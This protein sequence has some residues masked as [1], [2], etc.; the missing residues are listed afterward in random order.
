MG[1]H[2]GVAQDT[3]DRAWPKFTVPLLPDAT[4]NST[5]G[6]PCETQTYYV[7]TQVYTTHTH[8]Q[9]TH[10]HTEAK[11]NFKHQALSSRK[12]SVSFCWGFC[13]HIFVV[14][15]TFSTRDERERIHIYRTDVMPWKTNEDLLDHLCASIVYQ[16]SEYNHDHFVSRTRSNKE[17]AWGLVGQT[18]NF[19]RPW[20]IGL[21]A[22]LV[23]CACVCGVCVCGV[24]VST[25]RVRQA[26]SEPP[27]P[28]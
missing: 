25:R 2:Y 17:R 8:T 13:H 9:H 16:N 18:P 1:C 5:H 3:D 10:T 27:P 26:L 12:T 24:C 7:Y 28:H 4:G 6:D 22:G 19:F 21:A 11:N 23:V 15:V 20:P 14:L